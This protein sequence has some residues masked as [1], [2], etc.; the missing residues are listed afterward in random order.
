MYIFKGR[1]FQLQTNF[2]IVGTIYTSNENISDKDIQKNWEDFCG[3]YPEPDAQEFAFHLN[4][5]GFPDGETTTY[6]E[7]VCVEDIWE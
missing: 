2:D 3:N 1:L 4:S 7:A 5:I 6:F